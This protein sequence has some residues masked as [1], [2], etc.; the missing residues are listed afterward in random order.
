MEKMFSRNI[1]FTAFFMS[2]YFTNIFVHLSVIS[3]AS[4]FGCYKLIE[5]DPVSIYLFKGSSRSTR[6]RCEICPKLTR[7]IVKSRFSV[8][9]VNFEPILHFFSVL[10]LNR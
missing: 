8:F 9:I 10:V 4:Y 1:Y 7:T 6:K 2:S 5:W 3:A